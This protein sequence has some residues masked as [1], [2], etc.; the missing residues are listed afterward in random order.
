MSTYARHSP[1]YPLLFVALFITLSRSICTNL[2]RFA[3]NCPNRG[4]SHDFR[5]FLPL[6]ALC[7]ISHDLQ[8]SSKRAVIHR[9]ARLKASEPDA[10]PKEA[11]RDNII[12]KLL[13]PRGLIT[14]SFGKRSFVIT[15]SS[16]LVTR[17]DTKHVHWQLSQTEG[18][19][20]YHDRIKISG[21][22]SPLERRARFR[23][24]CFDILIVI[25]SRGN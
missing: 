10:C 12:N 19:L 23:R 3:F 20:R 21:L 17:A 4:T 24:A 7:D 16:V 13:N 15:I 5:V 22:G 25:R 9:V 18:K 2:V 11:S 1:N 8:F 6:V 14:L